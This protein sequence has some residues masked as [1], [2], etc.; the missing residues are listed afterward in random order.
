MSNSRLQFA[1]FVVTDRKENAVDL[2]SKGQARL[3]GDCILE[4]APLMP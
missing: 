2:E 3:L 4:L 1:C